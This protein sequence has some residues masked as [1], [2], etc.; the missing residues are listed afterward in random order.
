MAARQPSDRPDREPGL[1]THAQINLF[2]ARERALLERATRLEAE[3]RVRHLKFDLLQRVV[4]LTLGVAI[5]VLVSIGALGNPAMLKL[6]I[7]ATTGWG[8]IAAALSRR[9]SGSDGV[10]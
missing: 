7:A 2:V 5:G 9:R 4:L 1:R 8:L 3:L 6:A 10:H